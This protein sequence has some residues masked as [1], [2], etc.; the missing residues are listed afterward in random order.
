MMA[1][2]PIQVMKLP[3]DTTASWSQLVRA[4][5]ELLGV[6]ASIGGVMM[7]L[8][9]W[10]RFAGPLRPAHLRIWSQGYHPGWGRRT[11]L[12]RGAPTASGVADAGRE[13]PGDG[14]QRDQRPS[15]DEQD[16]DVDHAC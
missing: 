7:P 14:R 2:K 1:P 13:E 15:R 5:A 8:R 6:C 16:A 11:R 4:M 10:P 12:A 3:A 9:P